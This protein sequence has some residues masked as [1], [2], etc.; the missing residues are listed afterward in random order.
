MQYPGNKRATHVLV[1][2]QTFD[3]WCEWKGMVKGGLQT[4]HM[5]WSF[6]SGTE[7]A[8]EEAV[9]H[10]KK[11]E[12]LEIVYFYN[13]GR[14]PVDQLFHDAGMIAEALAKHPH[15]PWVVFGSELDYLKPVFEAAGIEVKQ[16]MLE[17]VIFDR[18]SSQIKNEKV[19]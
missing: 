1:F 5:G 9:E 4:H 16:Y 13:E 12:D 8:A 18:W 3:Q 19:A 15:K 2:G 6:T 17:R 11:R 14:I 10:I 7:L